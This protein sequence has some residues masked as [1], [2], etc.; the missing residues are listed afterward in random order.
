MKCELMII[1]GGLAGMA[2]S[3]FAADNG[4]K[5]FLAGST[6]ELYY[7]SGLLDLMGVFPAA[8]ENTFEN[9]YEAVEKIRKE[10]PSHPYAKIP[11]ADIKKS[12]ERFAEVL[13]TGGLGY[14]REEEKNQLMITSMGTVKPSHLIPGSMMA[15]VRAYQEKTP[16]L[17]VDIDR[18]KGFSAKQIKETLT[19]EWP[20]I[21]S[22]T[23]SFPSLKGEVFAETVAVSLETPAVL[24]QFAAS[25]LPHIKTGKAVGLP[26]V[27]GMEKSA[28]VIET[29]E[30]MLGVPVFEIPMLPPS[31]PGIR[32]RT[33]FESALK[34]KGV[35]LLAQKK[36]LSVETAGSGGLIFTVGN[37]DDRE[38]LK[39]KAD[40]AVLATGR[41]LGGGLKADY[42]TITET[43]F[44]IPVSQPE[45]R[46]GW[47]SRDFFDTDGHPINTAGI[48]TDELFRPLAGNGKPVVETLFAAGSII[49][50][51]DWTRMKSGA[52][53]AIA[54]AYA[55]VNSYLKL[56]K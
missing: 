42:T 27:L 8:G 18:M 56:K 3:L 15:G 43:L 53:V 46:Q 39:V 6:R 24:E 36:I 29:L 21:S 13:N 12:L 41:F 14:S 55:A 7:A 22:A 26:A 16:C 54:T 50:H 52:G 44:D 23:V 11:A 34:E 45:S 31:L 20:D 25:I 32:L 2:A 9:P 38:P 17:I 5:T 47:H 30:T 10:M 19:E 35:T 48:E 28:K 40:A 1:G 33:V 49:A 37:D 4:I 51:N